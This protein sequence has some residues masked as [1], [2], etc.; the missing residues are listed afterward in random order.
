MIVTQKKVAEIAGVSQM[1]V[2]Y[3]L[4]G[5]ELIAQETRNRVLQVADQL[6][7]RPNTSAVA[8]RQGRFGCVAIVE[9]T[10]SYRSSLFG[11]ALFDGVESVLAARDYHIS[12]VRMPDEKLTDVAVMPKILRQYMADGLLLNYFAAV[13]PQLVEL[14]DRHNIPAVWINSKQPHD[15]VYLDDYGG[16]RDAAEHLLKLGHRDIA[17]VDYCCLRESDTLPQSAIHYSIQ[18]RLK[19]CADAASE[20]GVSLRVLHDGR[21]FMSPATGLEAARRVFAAPDRPRAFIAYSGATALQI[22]Q[23]ATERGLSPVRDYSLI[24]FED[25][26]VAPSGLCITTMRHQWKSVGAAASNMLLK[27]LED[28]DELQSPQALRFTLVEGNTC[29]APPEPHHA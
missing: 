24:M 5:S 13:P 6:G 9:S 22:V 10:V 15:C 27:R 23:A 29:G 14:I 11:G 1:T 20:A 17:Y 3:A 19:G 4:R 16:G 28:R 12:V 2:S 25:W 8:I 7:Y 26:T 21:N 18:S